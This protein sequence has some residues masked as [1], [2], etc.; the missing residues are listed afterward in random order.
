MRLLRQ[1][2]PPHRGAFDEI[3]Q[4]TLANELTFLKR[5]VLN[6]ARDPRTNV[7]RVDG[8]HAPYE[9]GI[10]SY[11]AHLHGCYAHHRLRWV[12]RGWQ[13]RRGEQAHGNAQGGG[14]EFPERCG[15][16]HAGDRSRSPC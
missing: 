15:G 13:A 2:T 16:G 14:C 1:P 9:F 3:E 12:L 5:P 11:L 10:S 7:D 4:V 8:L 6:D